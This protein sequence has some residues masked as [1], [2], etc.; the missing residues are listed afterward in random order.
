[1]LHFYQLAQEKAVHTSLAKRAL[2]DASVVQITYS[3]VKHGV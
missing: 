1:M 2:L 3:R